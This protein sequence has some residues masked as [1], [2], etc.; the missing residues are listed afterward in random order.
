MAP[1]L[2]FSSLFLLSDFPFQWA[3]TIFVNG[4]YSLYVIGYQGIGRDSLPDYPVPRCF[5]GNGFWT[6]L[7]PSRFYFYFRQLL[8]AGRTNQN[9]IFWIYWNKFRFWFR[10]WFRVWFRFFGL[11]FWLF[12]ISF[13]RIFRIQWFFLWFFVP[14]SLN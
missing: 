12:L 5:G 9:S 6:F 11:G 10:F 14:I 3:L 7:A 4:T 8:R 1:A 2:I 13:W